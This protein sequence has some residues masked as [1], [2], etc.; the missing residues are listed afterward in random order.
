MGSNGSDHSVGV[1]IIGGV[2][3]EAN[4]RME[5]SSSAHILTTGS[6]VTTGQ[7]A[8]R[9]AA[10]SWAKADIDDDSVDVT[11]VNATLLLTKAIAG[12]SFQALADTGSLS[13][14]DV[15]IQNKYYAESYAASG[16]AGGVGVT[17]VSTDANRAAAETS[18]K[19]NASVKV[20]GNASVTNSV[21]IQNIGYLLADALGRTRKVNVSG[22]SIA[23]TVV[24]AVLK[25][26][27]TAGAQFDGETQVGGAVNVNSEIVRTGGYGIATA[28]AGGSGGANVSLVGA[29]VNHVTAKS[30]TANTV[31]L[32][33]A[34]TLSAGNV[35]VRAKS[36]TE[37]QAIAKSNVNVGLVL[38]G[39]LNAAS[40]THDKVDVLVDGIL[41]NASGTF[42][43]EAVGNTIS[44]AVAASEGGGGLVTSGINTA[45]AK[46][47]GSETDPQTVRIIV[48]DSIIQAVRD[49]TLR[50]YNT[51][52]ARANIERGLNVAAGN[53]SVSVLPTN[54]WYDT[55]VEVLEGSEVR[56]TEGNVSVL[57]EDAPKG[58]S[59]ARGTSIGIGVNS[60]VT[61][62]ENTAD[63][64]NT[65]RIHGILDAGEA[66]IVEAISSAQLNA[67][68]YADGGGFFE[69]TMLWS[70]NTL[71]RVVSILVEENSTLLANYGDLVISAEGG[72]RDSILTR[73]EVSSGGVVALLDV[74]ASPDGRNLSTS[75]NASITVQAGTIATAEA[76]LDVE[77]GG[78]LTTRSLG[79]TWLTTDENLIL[80]ADILDKNARLD[81]VGDKNLTVRNTEG[82]LNADRLYAGGD[83]SVTSPRGSTH[84]NWL[85]VMGTLSMDSAGN[86]IVYQ[87]IGDVTVNTV[88][89]QG[90]ILLN[91]QGHLKDVA[92]DPVKE[93]AAAQA[94]AAHAEAAQKAL[95]QQLTARQMYLDALEN[96]RQEL[97]RQLAG[98]EEAQRNL[99]KQLQEALQA[100]KPDQNAVNQ[101]KK[102]LEQMAGKINE[103]VQQLENLEAER[104][105]HQAVQQTIETALNQARKETDVARKAVENAQKALEGASDASITSGGN[106]DILLINGG[107]VGA[108]DNA[109]GVNVGGVLTVA[110]GEGR[111]LQEVW[112]ESPSHQP[113]HIAP[114]QAAESIVIHTVG[115][116]APTGSTAPEWNGLDFTAPHL[117]LN[118]TDGDTG[119]RY[120]PIETMA[121]RISAMGR[122]VYIHNHKDTE[123]GQI[124]ARETASI[125]SEGNI[126]AGRGEDDKI[127]ADDA[128]LRAKGNI[129]ST[130]ATIRIETGEVSAWGRSI[131]LQSEGDVVVDIIVAD[132]EV[133]IRT[134]GSVT[135]KGTSDA[136]IAETLTI[137]AGGYIGTW[138]NPLNIRV[139]GKVDLSAGLPWIYV[140][141][142]Y[143]RHE[144]TQPK[145]KKLEEVLQIELKPA[146]VDKEPIQNEQGKDDMSQ[147]M[148]GLLLLLLL[149]MILWLFWLLWRRRKEE[150]ATDT[151]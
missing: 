84:V 150:E 94:E 82:D 44:D 3:S 72:T 59:E 37:A 43:A 11:L 81:V 46:V 79:S 128:Q 148:Q 56:S 95:E 83:L 52:N 21:N 124:V 9:N 93:L 19:A 57:S 68:T 55:G 115:G 112:L 20:S 139:W 5:G 86:I 98:F 118:S 34:G 92:A 145:W 138:N 8:L 69:G 107:S 140:I 65:I 33:G 130:E 122:N 6:I 15:D 70:K 142:S 18:A 119:T 105:S 66:L 2:A 4:A 89:A 117:V 134:N 127:L 30:S 51:G 76:P 126:T 114:I 58:R 149:A 131:Y 73:S 110:A 135:D 90:D 136:I 62:G 120:R 99:E 63:T 106:L 104:Q 10:R 129:G 28:Q 54:A 60:N 64:T 116:I 32:Q 48:R 27:Q 22:V 77:V 97:E 24:D 31:F 41:V 88:K 71:N 133:F 53:L 26:G 39:S 103:T 91:I 144:S 80:I 78:I 45:N 141:N 74:N 7:L 50:A 111:M 108:A 49:I 85:K 42:T 40:S 61:Y 35:S 101:L 143:G 25:A 109:V 67:A 147:P 1:S 16:P 146:I 100:S 36:L 102:M 23:V 96:R 123:M 38:L 12:G 151:Q 125:V 121:D 87:A 13:A 29:G 14:G 17:L 137:L 75:G 132:K 113:L 47:G